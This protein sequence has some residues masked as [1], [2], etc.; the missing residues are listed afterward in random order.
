MIFLANQNT[1]RW[2]VQPKC[3][4]LIYIKRF[5]TPINNYLKFLESCRLY[6]INTI[7]TIYYLLPT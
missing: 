5:Q 6:K 3:I 4:Y 7:N 1:E 2:D